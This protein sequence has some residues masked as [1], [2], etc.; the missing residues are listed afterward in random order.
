MWVMECTMVLNDHTLYL[1]HNSAWGV[2]VCVCVPQK[3]HKA[4]DAL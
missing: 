1:R 3:C 4:R 2:C